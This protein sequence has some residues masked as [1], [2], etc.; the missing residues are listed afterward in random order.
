MPL[1]VSMLKI[2]G[3]RSS[4]ISLGRDAEHGDPAAVGHVRDHVAERV[5]VAGHLEADVEALLHAE[6]ALDVGEVA[7][8]RVD[9]ER[10]AH[11]R[12]RARAGR[13]SRR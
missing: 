4:V 5:R 10:R 3:F 8:A 2:T 11:L 7:L 9:R 1:I 13:G 6:L 12:A